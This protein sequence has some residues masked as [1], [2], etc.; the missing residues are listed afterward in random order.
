VG[1]LIGSGLGGSSFAGSP[2]ASVINV[3]LPGSVA[4]DGPREAA[5]DDDVTAEDAP[6]SGD[7]GPARAPSRPPNVAPAPA[8]ESPG[9][10][11]EPAPEQEKRQ[12]TDA[13]PLSGTVV[14]ARARSYVVALA[15]GRLRTVHAKDTVPQV[16]EEVDQT[17]ERLHNG[18]YS[19]A[20]FVVIGSQTRATLRGSVSFADRAKGVYTVSAAGVSML[21]RGATASLPTVGDEV[22]VRTRIVPADPPR[23][24]APQLVQEAVEQRD[25]APD[26]L[27]AAGKL[28]AIDTERR[29]LVLPA[30]DL[31]E[32]ES[33]LAVTV[34]DEL[35]L[36]SFRVGDELALTV[37]VLPSG[38][39][40]A[41]T[42]ASDNESADAADDAARA[43]GDQVRARRAASRGQAV[44]R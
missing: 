29:T 17:G 1:L 12:A 35:E 32:S 13:E 6:A 2:V 28:K 40:L 43:V 37:R 41:L 22:V 39:P 26:P 10:E 14:H 4:S 34:P 31:G 11:P 24:A 3:A 18:T 23:R 15:G 16:G 33:D 27:E 9:G 20:G 19:A 25:R 42:G 36:A 38:G 44:R 21:V 8:L 7:Q 30:D 5:G